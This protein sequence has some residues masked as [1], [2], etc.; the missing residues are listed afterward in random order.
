M[1]DL[2][3]KLRSNSRDYSFLTSVQFSFL[4]YPQSCNHHYNQFRTFSPPSV[5]KK[6]HDLLQSIPLCHQLPP[7]QCEATIHLLSMSIDLSLRTFHI[8]EIIQYV[9]F[10]V[11]LLQGFSNLYHVSVLRSCSLL[12][13]VSIVWGNYILCAHQLI[14]I[15]VVPTFWLLQIMLLWAPVQ[16]FVWT[17]GFV[18]LG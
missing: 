8:N 4:A 11:W 7:H 16:V 1:V 18:F 13:I 5:I 6:P 10:C 2:G 17:H 3:I 12:L 9:A 15:W 14:G